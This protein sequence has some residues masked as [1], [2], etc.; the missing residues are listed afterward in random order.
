MK[1]D[2]AKLI[3]N[4]KALQSYGYEDIVALEIASKNQDNWSK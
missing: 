3:E 4:I 2:L 1:L